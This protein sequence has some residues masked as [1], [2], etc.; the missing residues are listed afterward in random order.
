MANKYGF[1]S[2]E[3]QNKRL[4]EEQ[5]QQQLADEIDEA[6]CR[7]VAQRIGPIVLDILNAFASTEI[8]DRGL[9]KIFEDSRPQWIIRDNYNNDI[10][11]VSIRRDNSN[12]FSLHIYFSGD[13]AQF[14]SH[15]HVDKLRTAMEKE[16]GLKIDW[17]WIWDWHQV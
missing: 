3:E 8:A 9:F 7:S 6:E 17:N 11:R 4:E 10:V 12:I 14:P 15:K 13:A 1:E 5:K 16:A 2:P